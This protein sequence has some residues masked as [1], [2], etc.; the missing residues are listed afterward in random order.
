M[1]SWLGLASVSSNSTVVSE[2]QPKKAP[3]SISTTVAGTFAFTTP[4]CLKAYS[5]M[6]LTESGIVTSVADPLYRTSFPLP[7]MSK[8]PVGVEGVSAGV[9]PA[10]GASAGVAPGDPGEAL[11]SVLFEGSC[12]GPSDSS[13]VGDSDCGEAPSGSSGLFWPFGSSV[14]SAG[15]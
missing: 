4:V 14:L 10:L 15:K 8:S 1:A 6:T 11:F 13:G 2:L 12:E 9:A 7:S 5:P 3:F